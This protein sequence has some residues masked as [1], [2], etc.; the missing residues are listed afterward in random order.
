M[1]TILVVED[2]VP[3]QRFL[4]EMLESQ[5]YNTLGA[6]DASRAYDI[7]ANQL[8]RAH[9][10]ITDYHMSHGSGYDLINKIKGNSNLE[11]L[12]V[13]F[14]SAESDPAIIKKVERLGCVAWVKK[15]Y[16]AQILL[17]EVEKALMRNNAGQT[18][19]F[20]PR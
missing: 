16:R 18:Q 8:Q 10:V 12:P 20:L 17:K 11:N 6:S 19:M 5:G 4:R 15:P 7:L 14:L 1:R 13:I 2:F 9:L 3:V